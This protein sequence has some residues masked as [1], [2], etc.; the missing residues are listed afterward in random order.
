MQYLVL[1][2]S[3]HYES[4]HYETPTHSGLS[5]STKCVLGAPRFGRSQY[6]KQNKQIVNIFIY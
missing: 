3:K 6:D 1:Y 4:K 5:N 2:K